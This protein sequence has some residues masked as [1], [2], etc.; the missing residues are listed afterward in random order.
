L[1]ATLSMKNSSKPV[2]FDL[3]YVPFTVTERPS[4][5][6]AT[7]AATVHMCIALW[8]EHL[9]IMAQYGPPA[10][11]CTNSRGDIFDGVSA[12][13]TTLS[14]SKQPALVPMRMAATVEVM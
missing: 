5:I 12:I 2:F 9:V 1:S 6:A 7:W 10:A 11:S 14:S 8:E 13:D 3:M 4:A